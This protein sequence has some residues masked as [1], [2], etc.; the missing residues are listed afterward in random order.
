MTADE[1]D[2]GADPEGMLFHLRDSGKAGDRR[3]R[4]FTAACC[5][6]P[7]FFSFLYGP[8][9]E[10]LAVA[11]RYA[12][13]QADLGQLRLAFRHADSMGPSWCCAEDALS[14]AFQWVGTVR[15]HRPSVPNRV[16]ILAGLLREVFGNPRR[17]PAVEPGW[18]TWHGGVVA[19][20]AQA[21]YEERHLPSGLL[22]PTRLAVLAD[23]L[24]DAGCSDPR[25][26]GH[27]RSGAGHVRGCFAVDALRGIP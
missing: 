9:A 7:D 26:L 18:L 13:G 22:D 25:L 14:A 5:R 2:V 1:W 27:L 4:L 8:D 3:L 12:D 21:A 10:A 17:P 11:E 15:R 19:R 20:L 6:R 24:D 23:A 16:A